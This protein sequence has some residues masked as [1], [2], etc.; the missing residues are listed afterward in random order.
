MKVRFD[1]LGPCAAKRSDYITSVLLNIC[2]EFRYPDT[3]LEPLKF[4][5]TPDD[6]LRHVTY[7]LFWHVA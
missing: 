4:S 1:V 7:Y 5:S 6:V 3:M 2:S